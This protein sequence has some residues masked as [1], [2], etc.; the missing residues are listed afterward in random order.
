M[1]LRHTL[2][3]AV[4]QKE[5]FKFTFKTYGEIKNNFKNNLIKKNPEK[6]RI[7][8]T[9]KIKIDKINEEIC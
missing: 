8:T 3:I 6:A 5:N 4:R 2:T 7:Q 1:E 9:E